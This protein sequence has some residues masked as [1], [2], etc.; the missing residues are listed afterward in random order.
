MPFPVFA[1]GDV[2][3]ASDMN[4][5]GLWLVKTQTIGSAVS[6]VTVTSA[7]S[8]SYD[9][10]IITVSGGTASVNGSIRLQMNTSTGST[11]SAAGTYGNFGINSGITYNP[12]ATTSWTDILLGH[13]AGYAGV[14]NLAGPFASR[15]TYGF[16][17]A[18]SNASFY[19]FSLLE[20]SSNSNTGFTLTPAS[21][22]LTGGTIRVYG[23]RN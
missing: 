11:Y 17:E 6:S 12:A 7:F 18:V 1:S 14:I 19:K 10:Y 16:T 8:S 13:T 22:T 2:L 3:N 5:V 21:G 9:N 20:T 23:Y 15:P 4:A